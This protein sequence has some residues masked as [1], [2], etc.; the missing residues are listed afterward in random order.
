MRSHTPAF[1]KIDYDTISHMLDVF[2]L[3]TIMLAASLSTITV[4]AA[5]ATASAGVFSKHSTPNHQNPVKTQ[6]Q[7]PKCVSLHS[8]D[9]STLTPYAGIAATALHG[10]GCRKPRWQLQHLKVYCRGVNNQ[11]HYGPRFL[12]QL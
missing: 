1:P 2:W 4:R 12:V 5:D 11:Q 6:A 8:L 9:P 7:S 10:D 3:T